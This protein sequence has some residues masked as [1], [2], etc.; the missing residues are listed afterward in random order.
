MRGLVR[1][2]IIEKTIK[3]RHDMVQKKL[4]S[5]TDKYF[6]KLVRDASYQER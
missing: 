2:L 5:E 4:D 6:M 1:N 3:E